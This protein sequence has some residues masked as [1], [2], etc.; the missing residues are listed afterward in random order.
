MTKT[1]TLRPQETHLQLLGRHLQ[2]LVLAVENNILGAEH[3]V[4]VDLEVGTAVALDAAEAGVGVDLGE[5]NHVSGDLGH[6]GGAHGDG[7]IG[8]LCVAW[9]GE[10]SDLGVVDGSLDLA[11]VGGGDLGIDEEEGSSGVFVS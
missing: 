4:S 6:V 9:V 1:Q 10:T 7:E 11:V 2:S 3:D 8:H 5:G